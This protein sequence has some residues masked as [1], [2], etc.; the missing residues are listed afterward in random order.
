MLRN[1]VDILADC[2]TLQICATIKYTHSCVIFLVA[3]YG[4]INNRS[5]SGAILENGLANPNN[6]FRDGKRSKS[7]ASLKGASG[8]IDRIFRIEECHLGETGTTQKDPGANI[9]E[10]FAKSYIF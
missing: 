9:P 5:Q 10:R 8:Q 6:I 4:V 2:Q 7:G 3:I 1:C